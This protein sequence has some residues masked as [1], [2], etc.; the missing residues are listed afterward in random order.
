MAWETCGHRSRQSD[1]KHWAALLWPGTRAPAQ[2][3]L[4][5]PEAALICHTQEAGESSQPW[6]VREMANAIEHCEKPVGRAGTSFITATFVIIRNSGVVSEVGG[7]QTYR[8]TWPEP[9]PSLHSTAPEG[10]W[11]RPRDVCPGEHTPA[12]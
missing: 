6:S 4:P 8:V 12:L 10:H 7:F 11:R 5:S 3:S 9:K 1:N 2:V